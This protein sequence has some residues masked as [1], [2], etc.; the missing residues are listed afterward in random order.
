MICPSTAPTTAP[1][2]SQERLDTGAPRVRFYAG[3]PICSSDGW[4]IGTLCLIDDHPR[5]FTAT[6]ERD[7]RL[8]AARE[9]H[10]L[11][12]ATGREA[13]DPQAVRCVA[14]APSETYSA[15]TGVDLSAR[16]SGYC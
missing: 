13:R 10:A 4:R 11:G 1:I 15:L 6:D 5:T 2:A 12:R 9:R 14:G 3:H 16:L 7:L 8:R